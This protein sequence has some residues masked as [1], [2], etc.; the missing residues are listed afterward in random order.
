VVIKEKQLGLLKGIYRH[1]RS[2]TITIGSG[3]CNLIKGDY[4]Y[5]TIN[6]K[7]S[8]QPPQEGD[9]LFTVVNKTPVYYGNIVRL[10]SFYI[11]LHNVYQ[12]PFYNR[13]SVFSKW[14]K[15]GED[16]VMERC[17]HGRWA[18]RLR[19]RRFLR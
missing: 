7:Q 18:G 17:H 6:Y 11:G 9:L 12:K 13:D 16:A 4:Y 5:F 19:H 14:T 15:S 2:D 10:A 8:G 3:R 1:K